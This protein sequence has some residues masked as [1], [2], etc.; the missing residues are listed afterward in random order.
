MTIALSCPS[1][2]QA[3]KVKDEL[4]GR[5]VK[6]PKCSNVIAVLGAKTDSDARIT[7][8]APRSR[9]QDDKEQDDEPEGYERPKKKKKKKAKNNRGLLIGA[10][11]A[12]V[13]LIAIIVII[14]LSVSGTTQTKV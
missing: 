14:L 6:C 7:A 5:K 9:M 11:V 3:L 1:C 8:K 4:A 2:G 13:V 10:A 12:G